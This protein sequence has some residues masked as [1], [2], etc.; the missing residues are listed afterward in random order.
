MRIDLS[1]SFLLFLILSPAPLSPAQTLGGTIRGQVITGRD[2][3][4]PGV[5]VTAVNEETGETRRTIT[6]SRG[7][8]NL[9]ALAPG[10][11]RL[12]AET[13]GFRKHVRR[14]VSLQIGQSLRLDLSLEPGGPAEEIIVTA[15]RNLLEP[16]SMRLGAVVENRQIVDLPLDGRNSLQLSLLLPGTAPAAQGSPGSVRGEFAINVNGA[17]EDANNFILDGA[18]NNDP[19]LN[20]FA[21]NPPVDAI[22]EFEILT[23]SYDASFGRSAGAQV[24]V[25]LKSGT[26]AFHGTAYEFFRNAALDARNFFSHTEDAAPRYQRNQFGF[27]LGGPVRR[28]RTFF[29]ADYEGRR[30]REGITQVSNVPTELERKGDFSESIFPP[31]VDPYTQLP[32]PGGRIPDARINSIGNAIAA[33]YPLPNRETPGQNFVSSPAL[34]DREDHF[35]VRVDH[36]LSNR[37]SLTGRYSFSDQER[38][39]PFSGSGFARIPGFGINIPKRAQNLVLGY[40]QALSPNLIHQARFAFNRMAAGSFHENMGRSLNHEV[41]L[42]ELSSNPRDFGL[43]LVTV[44]GFSPIGDE[45]NNPQHS[46]TNVSQLMDAATYSRGRHLLKFGFELR[47]LQQNAYRDVQSRGFL[48]FSNFG[49]VSGNGLADMLLGFITYSGGAR[50]DNPQHLRSRSWNFYAQ[51][52]YRLRPDVTLLFGLRYEYNSPPVDRYDRANVYDPVSQTLVPVGQD[53]MPRS[54]YNPD[55]NNWG[56]RVGIAWSPDPS[57]RTVVRAGYGIYYDQSSLAPGEGLYFNQPYYDFNM[58]F[59][60]PGLPLTLNDPFPSYYP[61]VLPTSALGF[62]RNLRTAYFQHWNLT[63]A[64]QFGTGSLVELAYA[65]SKGTRILTARDSNQAAPSPIQPNPRPV[66]QFSDITFEESRGGSTYHSL[67]FRFQQRLQAGFA[68]LASYTFAKSLDT[69]STFFSSSGDANFPQNSAHPGAEKGRSNFDVRHRASIGYSYDLPFGPGKRFLSN[70]GF[71]TSLLTG[72]TTH[73]IVTLQRGRPF[74]V[75]LL[76]EIDNSNT[77]FASLGFGANNRPDRLSD[78]SLEDRGPERWFDTGA[79]RMAPYGSFGDA[80]RNILQGPGLRDASLSMIRN[81]R[82]SEGLDLQV[83]VEFFNAF[84]HTNFDLPDIF[85]GSPTFGKILSAG[86]PRRIQV[87]VKLIF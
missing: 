62:D 18:Y 48:T 31:P 52:S 32:F 1:A 40:D 45:Y 16:D 81:S 26:N 66:P 69:S 47:F 38:Y 57:N 15:S 3:A 73:G 30:V 5:P 63:A 84:N 27:S 17:R 44:S 28:N 53:G 36:S 23:S 78:S 35:D 71:P 68:A 56:P 2:T 29:F 19:K 7:E 43:S 22:R 74:T 61:L 87:G 12:E 54:G 6:G 58:Y 46:A 14:G 79:F 25:A 75:A 51:D 55:R 24:N 21:I 49:Q 82:V 11:Y 72:W 65:G 37:S 76:P 86:N 10:S 4:I 41:G 13:A 20:T 42:P 64:R 77:G 39:Q 60:L 33:L 50:L 34:R 59:P 83:R 8:F 9:P 80:G 67:Q 85:L 70:N